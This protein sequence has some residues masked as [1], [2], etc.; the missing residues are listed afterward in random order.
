MAAA[1]EAFDILRAQARGATRSALPLPSQERV[2]RTWR[3]LAFNV[4]A[5]RL[6]SALG[7]VL[8]VIAVP[9]LTRVRVASWVSGVANLRGR[10]LPV[11]DLCGY[12]G[13]EAT[14]PRREWRVLVVQDGDLFCGLMVEQSFGMLQFELEDHEPGDGEQPVPGLDPWPQ[15]TV[16]PGAGSGG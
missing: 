13:L 7:E 6:V 3:G 10:L 9:T 16:P 11:I 2:T 12:L 8:E 15:G 4:G 5:T 1:A 14:S